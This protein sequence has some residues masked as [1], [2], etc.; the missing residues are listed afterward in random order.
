MN[1]VLVTGASGFVGGHLVRSLARQG[2]DTVGVFHRPGPA[3]DKRHLRVDLRDAPAVQKLFRE[4]HF[5][6]VFH[7]AATGVSADTGTF[8]DLIQI[9]TLAAAALGRCALAHGV[10][11][12]IYVGSAFE[13][14]PQA[15]AMDESTPLG[16][17]NFYGASKTAGWLL[18]DALHR[19][20]GLPLITFRPFSIY[21][22]GEHPAKLV[23]YVILQ[24]LRRE[25]IR[26]TLGNQVRDYVFVGDVV[27]ALRLGLAG[28]AAPG[29]V[30][31]IGTG[32][33][34]ARSVRQLVEQIL[35]IMDAPIRLCWFDS[36]NRS[37]RDPPYLV[38]DPTRATLELGWRPRV[39]L[40]EG[41]A[42]TCEWYKAT[43]L[44]EI[45]A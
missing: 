32:P 7:L 23:P 43:A 12:F 40:D 25:P 19:L 4:F 20:E 1:P 14:R 18:L 21:G 13:Y 3:E 36:A 29:Q 42:R 2:F 17:P 28:Q 34:D 44:E 38:S 45:P 10:Q 41:L 22:P 6:A 9:N 16:A 39:A 33:Q 27:E 15:R 5:S 37:R 31:N 24:A 26:L 8:E 35:A 30:F 11:R